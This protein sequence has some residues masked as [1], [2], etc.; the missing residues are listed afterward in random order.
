MLLDR[1]NSPDAIYTML[2]DRLNSPDTIYIM[3]LDR[4]NS[5]DLIRGVGVPTTLQNET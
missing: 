3:L 4:L 2:L 1:L 5:P